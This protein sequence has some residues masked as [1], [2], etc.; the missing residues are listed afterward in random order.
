MNMNITLVIREDQRDLV[1]EVDVSSMHLDSGIINETL[2]VDFKGN[3]IYSLQLQV[4]AYS[5]T[6]TTNNHYIS[7]L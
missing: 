4:E 6:L 3:K 7:M 5:R 1:S 2:V